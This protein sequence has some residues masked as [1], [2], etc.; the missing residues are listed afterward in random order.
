VLGSDP[1]EAGGQ[2]VLFVSGDDDDAKSE[3]TQMFETA[4][5]FVIDLGGLRPG[6]ELQQVGGPLSGVNLIRLAGST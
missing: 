3:V 2:R 1:H 4:G 6:G 5:F